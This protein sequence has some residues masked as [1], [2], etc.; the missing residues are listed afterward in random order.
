MRILVLHKNKE[1]IEE[2]AAVLNEEW[3]S[4]YIPL[5]TSKQDQGISYGK[6]MESANNDAKKWP[7]L[8][9]D[10]SRDLIIL[11]NSL[12]YFPYI[13]IILRYFPI[14]FGRF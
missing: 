4:I 7:I 6:G 8:P 1:H 13:T 12:R 9:F 10:V 14:Y 5:T 2:C 3:P 11:P